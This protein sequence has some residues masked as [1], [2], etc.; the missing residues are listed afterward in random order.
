M[1]GSGERNGADQRGDHIVGAA[2]LGLRGE[3][4]K[5]AMAHDR[6]GE[7][8]DVIPGRGEAAMQQY[9]DEEAWRGKAGAYNLQDRIDAGWPIKCEGDPSTVMGLP[10]RRLREL[11]GHV[12]SDTVSP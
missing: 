5:Q 4:Q 12:E 3:G 8:S 9:L 11:F 1:D 6:R 2:P 7:R 10:M